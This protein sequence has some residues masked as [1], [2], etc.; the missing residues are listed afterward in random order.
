MDC[1]EEEQMQRRRQEALLKRPW[2]ADASNEAG[3]SK[4]TCE[5][6][7]MH[8]ENVNNNAHADSFREFIDSVCRD[9]I[10]SHRHSRVLLRSDP[11][12]VAQ[13]STSLEEIPNQRVLNHGVRMD[14]N[15]HVSHRDNA[16]NNVS[17]FS[18]R[19]NDIAINAHRAFRSQIDNLSVVQMCHVCNECYV[20][21][22]VFQTQDGPKCARCKSESGAHRFSVWNNMDPKEQPH[23]LAVLTQVEEM[24]IARISLILQVSHAPG[25]QYK[26]SGHTISFPQYIQSVT[27]LLSPRVENLDVLIVHRRG[28]GGRNYDCFVKRNAVRLLPERATD[29]S[30]RLS[31]VVLEINDPV[32]PLDE[33]VNISRD[34]HIDSIHH[35]TSFASRRPNTLHEMEQIRVWLETSEDE[36]SDLVEWP[37][38]GAS[39]INEYNIE[40]LFDMAFPTLFPTGEGEWLQPRS[41]KIRLHEYAEHLMKYRDHRFAKHPRFRYFIMSMI[42]RHRSQATG[43]VFVKKNAEESLPATIHE[44]RTQLETL[45]DARLA[46][47]VMKFAT[48]LRD[49]QWPDLHQLMPGTA[50][51]DPVAARKWHC[52]NVIQHPH[53][54]AKYMHLR[55]TIFREEVLTKFHGATE[56]WS[57]YEWQ[58]RGSPHIHRFLWLRDAPDMDG[59]DWED[60]AQ[61]QHAKS[62]FDRIVHAWN[63]RDV[64]QRNIQLQ[65]NALDDPCLLRTNQIF[66]TDVQRDY[67]NLVNHVEHHTLCSE[68][69][70]LRKKG[71][72]MKP[73]T[74]TYVVLKYIA[75]YAAKSE[76]VYES[77]RD[78]LLQI[79][80]IEDPEE[81]AARA[82][83]RFLSETIVEQDI[84]AQ[85]TCHMLLSLPLIEC[86]RAFVVLNVGRKVFQKIQRHHGFIVPDNSF[87]HAYM[88]RPPQMEHLPLIEVA[89]SWT[90]SERRK[91]EPWKPREKAAV[92]RVW[93]HFHA[94][95]SD[96][97]EQ[98]EEF[99]WSEL[100]LYKPFRTFDVDIGIVKEVIIERWRSFRY[101]AWHIKRAEE[102]ETLVD[103]DDEE[104]EF[105]RSET[106]RDQDEWEIISV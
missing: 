81:P 102:E 7:E 91:N 68:G 58:H 9:A 8:E 64:H 18:V 2:V 89:R 78:M 33:N 54:L 55:Y 98:F 80:C 93:P 6:R 3:P 100:V 24:L 45:P 61:V 97:S 36:T 31:T 73:V 106:N 101:H 15:H 47:K 84:G 1:N 85:E 77:Y 4:R 22:K 13:R 71:S 105:H 59:L 20:G 82:Y 66:K 49:M 69:Y 42:M 74:S 62:F 50:P 28:D 35:P 94:A 75:K 53:I 44:L 21:I 23:V 46:E 32:R 67:E 5:I 11:N 92:V 25:G 56:F 95:P 10:S 17:N 70:C 16:Q 104:T 37:D 38:L 34:Q 90:Y 63:P 27:S 52:N 83:K 30:D 43:A 96:D 29:I 39:P 76:K 12:N 41:M 19:S 26:Y 51:R 72:V 79:S 40:G 48:T 103:D 57:R 60:A 87:I 65:R 14:R 99:C 86:S 88:D